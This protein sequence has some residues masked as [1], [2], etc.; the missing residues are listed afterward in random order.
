MAFTIA[1][2]AVMADDTVLSDAV[3][4]GIYYDA[5][6]GLRRGNPDGEPLA[7]SEIPEGMTADGNTLTLD[8]VKFN[9]TSP[10]AISVGDGITV[11]IPENSSAYIT[12]ACD[13]EDSVYG[14]QLL[15]N[16]VIEA[17][18]DLNVS[19]SGNKAFLIG[20]ISFGD[21]AIKGNGTVTA[22]ETSGSEN[23]YGL[24]AVK[25]LAIEGSVRVKAA[26][27][28]PENYMAKSD[29]GIV[30]LVASGLEVK[31][32]ASLDAAGGLN[33]FGIEIKDGGDITVSDNAVID[34]SCGM[35]LFGNTEKAAGSIHASGRSAVT[36]KSDREE[37]GESV[38]ECGLYGS[39]NV[40]N[41][42]FPES[43]GSIVDVKDDAIVSVS[44]KSTYADAAIGIKAAA[45]VSVTGGASSDDAYEL[46]Y[47]G[48]TYKI[49][50]TDTRAK[51]IMFKKTAELQATTAPTVSLP[52]TD[53][54][55]S[56]RFYDAV[57]TVYAEG[58][59]D[60]VTDTEFAPDMPLTRGM[61]IT[62]IGRASGAKPTAKAEFTDVGT[63]TYYAGYIAWAAENGIVDGF[64]DGTF[65]PDNS[66]TR[67]QAVVILWRCAKFAGMDVSVGDNTNILS[68]A[69]ADKIS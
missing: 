9:T 28:S 2:P 10:V 47:D 27:N 52:F 22:A 26:A 51:Y 45:G 5:Q 12:V 11:K 64:D 1:A 24:F 7:A 33:S 65:K 16:S 13:D 68:Y 15:G 63:D 43:A 19:V 14:L 66:V 38:L 40:E 36:V 69:D 41:S 39:L 48:D 58:L 32:D 8:N 23:S 67:E 17:D 30:N 57:G 53:V 49:T 20:I 42:D 29:N 4:Y 6:T 31:D 60:G 18:G 56:D 54:K 37:N 34:S 21:M 46:V 61:L 62:I 25:S 35:A 55:T 44:V 50:N 3:G 59:M